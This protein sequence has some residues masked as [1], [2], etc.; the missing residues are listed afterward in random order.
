MS[1]TVWISKRTS[2]VA[3]EKKLTAFYEFEIIDLYIIHLYYCS[4]NIFLKL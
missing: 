4:W 1:Q 3:C 2:S